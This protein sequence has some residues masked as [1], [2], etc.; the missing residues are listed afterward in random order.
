MTRIS[1]LDQGYTT[2]DLSVYPE[3]IDSTDTLYQAENNATTTL[4]NSLSYSSRIVVVN[5]TTG[6]PSKGL[7]RVGPAIGE[8]GSPELIYYANKTGTTFK[9]LVR[10]FTGSRQNFW[11][12]GSTAANAIMA[13]H[14]NALKDAVL[15]IEANLGITAEEF[16]EPTDDGPLNGILRHQENRFLS[17][18]PAFRAT[19]TEGP[20]PLEVRFQNFSR[21]DPLRYLWNFGDGTNSTDENPT[22]TYLNEGLFTVTLELINSTSGTGITQKLNYIEVND[23]LAPSFFYVTPLSGTSVETANELTAGGSPT[24]PTTF[25]FVDQTDT[26]IVERFWGFGDDETEVETDPDVHSTTH[27]YSEPGTYSVS[28]IIVLTDQK[29][30]RIFLQDEIIVV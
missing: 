2:G 14:H 15:N 16:A 21:G 29:R 19:Y 7:I 4:K 9:E 3:A 6:F 10:G 25:Q 1:S 12:K 24:N 8:P 18:K 28:L 27:I 30:R 26:N 17:P 23:D 11:P 22:H 20:S 13:E 5:D